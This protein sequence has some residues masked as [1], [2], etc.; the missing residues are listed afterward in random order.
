MIH[1]TFFGDVMRESAS[2]I[3][4]DQL[5]IQSDLINED[6]K[7][8]LRYEMLREQIV[9]KENIESVS[10]RY[11]YSSRHFFWCRDRFR[12]YGLVGLVDKPPGP[13]RP[14]KIKPDVERKIL[15]YRKKN[16][17]IYDVSD[18]LKKDGI[19][20]T[21]KSVDNVLNKHHKPKKKRGRKPNK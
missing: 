1:V 20:I 8:L 11:G 17:S 4:Y 9:T 18:E 13:K 10:E 2:Y 15:Y 6:D 14:H 21:P 7:A 16:L 19:D 3:G 12:E 5:K